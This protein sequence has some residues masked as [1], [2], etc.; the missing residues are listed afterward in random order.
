[1]PSQEHYSANIMFPILIANLICICYHA[2]FGNELKR[3]Y[4]IWCAR[5]VSGMTII[6]YIPSQKI[7]K[8]NNVSNFLGAIQRKDLNRIAIGHLTNT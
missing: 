6:R 5:L 3:R 8:Q 1:M 2:E 4:K 7:E